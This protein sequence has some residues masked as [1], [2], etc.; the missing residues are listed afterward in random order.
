MHTCNAGTWPG[1][2]CRHLPRAGSM[3]TSSSSA[4]SLPTR[5]SSP[6]CRWGPRSASR[7]VPCH[8][9]MY[10]PSAMKRQ[11]LRLNR[12]RNLHIC[13]PLIGINPLRGTGNTYYA[14]GSNFNCM[15]ELCLVEVVPC[16]VGLI[17]CKVQ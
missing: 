10:N 8:V 15:K 7:H 9:R 12:L 11:S 6:L 2:S 1:L 14:G 17:S 13:N 16:R 3:T 4:A 5:T